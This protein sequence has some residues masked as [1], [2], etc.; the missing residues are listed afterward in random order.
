MTFRL[1]NKPDCQYYSEGNCRY[2]HAPQ[3]MISKWPRCI[4]EKPDC[5]IACC[6]RWPHHRAMPATVEVA[7]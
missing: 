3:P 4:L 1:T 2:P 7:A 6:V 5:R